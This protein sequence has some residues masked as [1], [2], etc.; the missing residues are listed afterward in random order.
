MRDLDE[1]RINLA[2]RARARAAQQSR[3]TLADSM[4][5]PV[6][7]GSEGSGADTIDENF[8]RTQRQ[9]ARSELEELREQR[10]QILVEQERL[11]ESE[12]AAAVRR[13][14]IER[15]ITEQAERQSQLEARRTALTQERV[16]LEREEAEERDRV[17]ALTGR[18]SRTPVRVRTDV[19]LAEVIQ[20]LERLSFEEVDI[21]RRVSALRQ[22]LE[23][24][25]RQASA[26]SQRISEDLASNAEI[27]QDYQQILSATEGALLQ[28]Q[29]STAQA[30]TD[31]MA[32]ARGLV[33]SA[34]A[35]GELATLQEAF[36]VA[37]SQS[38]HSLVD[39]AE[40]QRRI[41]ASSERTRDLAGEEAGI[42]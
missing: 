38:V 32:M 8:L 19:R 40:I 3:V 33:H 12:G 17:R 6:M 18:S 24:S 29:S 22:E 23:S 10:F 21:R 7:L 35:A 5:L 34:S 2:S 31:I 30:T 13:M 15:E 26:Q 39:I 16:N 37:S 9:I 11:A 36:K 1:E 14:E 20:N 42:L 25:A 28:V 41:E 27:M 4:I